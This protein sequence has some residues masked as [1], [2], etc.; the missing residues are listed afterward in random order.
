MFKNI[1]KSIIVLGIIFTLVLGLSYGT[2][3]YTSDS[4]RATEML[5]SN[6][7]YGI[8]ITASDVT[9]MVRL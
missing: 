8:D 7:S 2:F 1:S 9:V 5:V 3:I 4:Y 6:L